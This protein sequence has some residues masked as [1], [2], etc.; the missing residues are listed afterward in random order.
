MQKGS[1]TSIIHG[2]R[3]DGDR[4]FLCQ[5]PHSALFGHSSRPR[6][7]TAVSRVERR[8][9]QEAKNVVQNRKPDK[10]SFDNLK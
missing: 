3:E 8:L 5:M 4:R 9:R 7:Q 1:E 6:Q 10:L 2:S